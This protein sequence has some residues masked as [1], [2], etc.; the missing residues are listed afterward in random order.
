MDFAAAD[1]RSRHW[2]MKARW[3]LDRVESDNTEKMLRIKHAQNLSVLDYKLEQ[4]AFNAHW[5]ESNKLIS[6]T[7]HLNFPWA[8]AHEDNTRQTQI[9][10]L[11]EEWKRRF[12]DPDDP[13]VKDRYKRV[14]EAMRKRGDEAE[15]K[16]KAR[17]TKSTKE[18][19]AAVN[20][21]WE[22]RQARN[23]PRQ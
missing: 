19:L 12:G 21:N 2:W 17:G 10:K 20:K 9:A 1:L 23:R 11:M 4:Q 15:A 5:D 13:A 3:I 22:M 16:V 14:A 18:K 7:Y 8:K 6:A